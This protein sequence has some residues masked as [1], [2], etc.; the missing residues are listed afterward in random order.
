MGSDQGVTKAKQF[1]FL[2]NIYI[3]EYNSVL[4]GLIEIEYYSGKSARVLYLES[5]HGSIS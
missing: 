5:D 4:S 2:S 1:N 3:K